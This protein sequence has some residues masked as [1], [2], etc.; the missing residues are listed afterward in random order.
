MVS[1]GSGAARLP[2]HQRDAAAAWAWLP[3]ASL[4]K[5]CGSTLAYLAAILDHCRKLGPPAH[6]DLHI[7]AGWDHPVAICLR[8]VQCTDYQPLAPTLAAPGRRDLGMP[9]IQHL[10]IQY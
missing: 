9:V 8:P 1:A 3:G 4:V 10:A 7:R 6:N 2:A 5:C